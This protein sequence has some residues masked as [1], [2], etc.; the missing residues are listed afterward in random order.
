MEGDEWNRQFCRDSKIELLREAQKARRVESKDGRDNPLAPTRIKS[1]Q[2]FR[3]AGFY[4]YTDLPR[5]A[6][7]LLYYFERPFHALFLVALRED[8]LPVAM[9][10]IFSRPGRR[11]P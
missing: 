4:L 11:K 5:R 1:P 2:H 10:F 7:D 9:E 6:I 8:K 3:V